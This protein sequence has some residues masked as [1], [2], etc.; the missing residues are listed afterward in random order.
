VVRRSAFQ[1]VGGFRTDVLHASNVDW[2]SRAASAQLQF[3]H[4]EHIVLLRRIH[5]TNM[6]IVDVTRGRSDMLRVI[7]DHHARQRR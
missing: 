1:R 6:G 7:R 3:G 2:V 4:V 5:R